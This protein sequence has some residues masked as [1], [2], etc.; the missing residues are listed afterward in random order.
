MSETDDTTVVIDESTSTK[1]ETTEETTEGTETESNGGTDE[2][3]RKQQEGEGS[4]HSKISLHLHPFKSQD[5]TLEGVDINAALEITQV[6]YSQLCRVHPEQQQWILNGNVLDSQ[7]TL[8]DQGVKDGDDVFIFF[9]KSA[10]STVQV[11]TEKLET[12]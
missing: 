2:E 11:V 3:K 5:V 1:Q 4:Q 6:E 10:S 12:N 8:A 9:I 7:K